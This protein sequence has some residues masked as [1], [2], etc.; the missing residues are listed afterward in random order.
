[1]K[2][3]RLIVGKE[4]IMTRTL[5]DISTNIETQELD[6]LFLAIYFNDRDKVTEFKNQNPEIYAKKNKYL[7]DGNITFDLTNLTLLNHKIWFDNDWREEI[8]LFIKEN[9]QQTNQMIDFWRAE[10]EKPILNRK[11]EYNQYFEYFYC[12]DPNDPENNEEII[13][14]HI[15]YFLEKG[16]REIDLMLY[17]RVECFDFIETKKLLEKGAKSNIHFYEDGDSNA[18]SR[19]SAE[20][21][22]LATCQ[23]IPEFQ[24]FKAKGYKQNFDISRMFGELLGLAAHEEMY[25]LL[26]KYNDVK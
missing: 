17:N 16:F 13:L 1:V 20:C 24:I 21:S 4:L 23:I 6:K 11:I 18:F 14:D 12:D 7:L 2:D 22:Y 8:M 5:K 19:I 15:S 10:G 25:E 3:T 9:R 26:S